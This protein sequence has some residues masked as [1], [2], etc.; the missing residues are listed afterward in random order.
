[1]PPILIGTIEEVRNFFDKFRNY[2]TEDL[3]KDPDAFVKDLYVTTKRPEYS[4]EDQK[5]LLKKYG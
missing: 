3:K 5:K 2:G 1:M 4:E